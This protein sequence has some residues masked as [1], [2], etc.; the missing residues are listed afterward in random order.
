MNATG[1]P[2]QVEVEVAFRDID[3]MGHVNNAVFFSYMEFARIKYVA[4]LFTGTSLDIHQSLLDLPLILVEATCTYYSPALLGEKLTLG[5]GVSRFGNK[6][7]DL[8]YRFLGQ[9]GRLVATGKTIQVMYN[10][11]T[12]SAFPIPAEI[13]TKVNAFQDSWMPPQSRP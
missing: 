6:S 4:K 9:D 2:Y 12:K 10:Y 1:F 3:A 7:F 8:L 11:A 5:L 13:R